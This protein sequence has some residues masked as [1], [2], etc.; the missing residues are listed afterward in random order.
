MEQKGLKEEYEKISKK[1]FLPKFEDLDEEFEIRSIE[2]NKFGILIK[3][4]LRVITNKL[5]IFMNYLEPV[6]NAPPQSLHALIEIRGISEEER[7]KMFE[8]YKEISALLHENL[9]TELMSEKDIAIQINK[10]WKLW[11]K[12]KKEELKNLNIITLAWKKEEALPTKKTDYS[13]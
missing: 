3:A 7:S 13:G 6:I 12:I 8:F 2:I 4:I 1:Y 5:N 10:I 11:P 9:A